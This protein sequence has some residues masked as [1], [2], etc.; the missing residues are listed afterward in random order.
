MQVTKL[1]QY[2]ETTAA[3]F[4]KTC[5]TACALGFYKCFLVIAFSLVFLTTVYMNRYSFHT[6]QGDH[7]L[8]INRFTG[9]RCR[10]DVG[11][12]VCFREG[13]VEY[14]YPNAP[15]PKEAAKVVSKGN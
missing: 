10:I 7:L 1:H 14:E 9:E 8:R 15:T 6:E 13:E 2:T 3:L 11:S 12:N 4:T 5:N